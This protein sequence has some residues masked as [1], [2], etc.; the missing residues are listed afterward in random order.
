[1]PGS[2]PAATGPE[3]RLWDT[4]SSQDLQKTF[5]CTSSSQDQSGRNQELVQELER[6]LREHWGFNMPEHRRNSPGSLALLGHLVFVFFFP[7]RT[8][9]VLFQFTLGRPLGHINQGWQ[10]M[11]GSVFCLSE[12]P[13]SRW[14]RFIGEKMAIFV[15][16]KVAG[17]HSCGQLII[18]PLN[19][20]C[21]LCAKIMAVENLAQTHTHT[22]TLA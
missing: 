22:H 17:P 8:F 10:Q 14:Q 19:L 16:A 12:G 3:A 1:M 21:F 5:T 4:G 7:V 9:D 13:C 18:C 11:P 15:E 2:N 20:I 6:N